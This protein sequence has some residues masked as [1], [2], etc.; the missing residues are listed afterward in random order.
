MI[1]LTN[2]HIED[3]EFMAQHGENLTG[4]AKRLGTTPD[5]LA[6]HLQRHDRHDI[7]AKLRGRTEVAA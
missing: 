7:L 3:A 5:T 1:R 2:N 4:A 6:R